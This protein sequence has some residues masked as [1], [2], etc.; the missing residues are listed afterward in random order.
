M[1]ERI[2]IATKLTDGALA[3]RLKRITE[4]PQTWSKAERDELVLE[5]AKRLEGRK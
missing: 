1:P 2:N 5:A 4:R 3:D